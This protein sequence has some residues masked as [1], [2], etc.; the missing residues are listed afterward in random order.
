[1]GLFKKDEFK[2]AIKNEKLGEEISEKIKE[3]INKH[4]E[5]FGKDLFEEEIDKEAKE[6]LKRFIQIL[7]DEYKQ[8]LKNLEFKRMNAV[9]NDDVYRLPESPERIIYFKEGLLQGYN[10]FINL[11]EELKER[12][13]E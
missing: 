10:V 6:I 13:L 1:M 9:Q 2:I 8:R 7:Y 3:I 5:E 4:I 12:F 11:L